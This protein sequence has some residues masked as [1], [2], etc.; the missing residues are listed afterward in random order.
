MRSLCALAGLLVVTSAAHAADVVYLCA[1]QGGEEA[2]LLRVTVSA[3]KVDWTRSGNVHFSASIIQ[4][5]NGKI[6]TASSARI[7]T[8]TA[9]LFLI[10]VNDSPARSSF[11]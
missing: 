6:V 2:R 1:Y 8:F 4:N 11:V 9:D 3:A 5:S 10:D 7:Q